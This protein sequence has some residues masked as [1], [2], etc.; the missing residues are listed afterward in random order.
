[1]LSNFAVALAIALAVPFLIL[2]I[3]VAIP[4]VWSR[5][6]ERREDARKTLA[7]VV[8]LAGGQDNGQDPNQPRE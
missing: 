3:G 7:I 2:T 5:S 6:P 8:R 4:A 1:M